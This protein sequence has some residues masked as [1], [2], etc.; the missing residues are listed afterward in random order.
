MI[1]I[2]AALAGAVIG[3]VITMLFWLI[4]HHIEEKEIL[5]NEQR[6]DKRELVK[7]IMRKR[8]DTEALCTELNQIPLTFSDDPQAKELYRR[9]LEASDGSTKT[10]ILS[11]LVNHLAETMNFAGEIRPSDFTRGLI[12]QKDKVN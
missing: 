11:D 10:V 8:M 1:E 12:C 7:N 6:Q 3:A 4:Q 5:D 9:L 2:I